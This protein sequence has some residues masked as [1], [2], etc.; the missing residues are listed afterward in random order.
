MELLA[1][2]ARTETEVVQH[3]ARFKLDFAQVMGGCRLVDYPFH[4]ILSGP[5]LGVVALSACV[6]HLE[7]WGVDR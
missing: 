3:G 5:S 4:P 7:L 1:G 6:V 2:E